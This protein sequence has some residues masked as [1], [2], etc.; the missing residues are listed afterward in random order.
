MPHPCPQKLLG[1]GSCRPRT[2]TIVSCFL[3]PGKLIMTGQGSNL[4]VSGS[5]SKKDSLQDI[6]LVQIPACSTKLFPT[7]HLCGGWGP[8]MREAKDRRVAGTL[9][10]PTRCYSPKIKLFGN[11]GGFQRW[12]LHTGKL[13]LGHNEN[14]PSVFYKGLQVWWPEPIFN[15]GN[16]LADKPD[17][18]KAQPCNELS[19]CSEREVLKSTLSQLNFKTRLQNQR[20]ELAIYTFANSTHAITQEHRRPAKNGE[21]YCKSSTLY[22]NTWC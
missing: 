10:S 21:F 20:T 5:D 1:N 19:C 15:L 22:S 16:V 12:N 3:A 8:A 17:T 9:F 7:I 6:H 2:I 13:W 18:W 11:P 4:F 14:F